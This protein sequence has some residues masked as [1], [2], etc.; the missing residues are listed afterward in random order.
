MAILRSKEVASRS[1]LPYLT[2]ASARSDGG[3]DLLD[4]RADRQIPTGAPQ[5]LTLAS[6]LATARIADAISANVRMRIPV[7]VGVCDDAGRRG[8]GAR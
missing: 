6:P 3:G 4:N 5:A 2:R 7:E 1:A 8:R